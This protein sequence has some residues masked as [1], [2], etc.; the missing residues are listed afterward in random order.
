M[1]KGLSLCPDKGTSPKRKEPAITS[2]EGSS[3]ILKGSPQHPLEGFP[4]NTK[5][6]IKCL[7]KKS[8]RGYPDI[9]FGIMPSNYSLGPLHHYLVD[10][11][12]S[13]RAQLLKHKSLWPSI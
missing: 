6:I 9:P 2:S 11:S 10:S 8:R 5:G 13:P 12:P 1:H 4:P 7:V 3:F